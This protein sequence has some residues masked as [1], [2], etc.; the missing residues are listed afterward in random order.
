MTV[1]SCTL[2]AL[3]V[4]TTGLI[5]TENRASD[6]SEHIHRDFDGLGRI[7]EEFQGVAMLVENFRGI[8]LNS[9]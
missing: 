6:Y 2:F 3:E 7:S 8:V 9:A 4:C 1:A 5:G